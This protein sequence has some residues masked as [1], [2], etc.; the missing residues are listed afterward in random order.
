MSGMMI[1]C[2]SHLADRAFEEVSKFA[3]ISI[4]ILLYYI[5][6]MLLYVHKLMCHILGCGHCDTKSKRSKACVIAGLLLYTAEN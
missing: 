4:L 1:D 5:C 3:Q 2:H 6:Y